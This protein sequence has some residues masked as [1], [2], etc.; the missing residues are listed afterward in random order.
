MPASQIASQLGLERDQVILGATEL[1]RLAAASTAQ[2]DRPLVIAVDGSYPNDRSS[3]Y[4]GIELL[5][6]LRLKHK[7]TA[8]ILLV[9]FQ[10][11]EDILAKHPEHLIM[12]APGNRYERLPLAPE[13]IEGLKQLLTKAGELSSN[14]LAGKYK[15]YLASAFDVGRF[16]HSIANIYALK[17]LWELPALLTAGATVVG[18]PDELTKVLD[19]SLDMHIALTLHDADVERVPILLLERAQVLKDELLEALN[20][21]QDRMY[22]L[23]MERRLMA[24]DR[25]QLLEEVQEYDLDHQL[26]QQIVRA[27]ASIKQE[28]ERIISSILAE[29]DVLD[30][31]VAATDN[32]EAQIAEARDKLNQAA[33]TLEQ[34]G[35]H[36]KLSAIGDLRVVHV[37]DQ[38]SLGWSALFQRMVYGAE[39]QDD[40][41]YTAVNLATLAV[42]GQVRLEWTD[43]MFGLIRAAI[44]HT[45]PH[46]L[47]LDLRL[48]PAFDDRQGGVTARM[49]GAEILSRIRAEYR[50][51]PVIVTTASNKTWGYQE[52]MALGADGYWVKEGV[53]GIA[54]LDSL[55][56]GYLHLYRQLQA[57]TTRKYD[58]LKQV[59][60]LL[61]TLSI[62]TDQA[63][64]E[65]GVWLNGAD[66]MGDRTSVVTTL[67]R[68]ID[69]MRAYLQR[70]VLGRAATC[71]AARHDALAGIAIT[72]GVIFEHVAMPGMSSEDRYKRMNQALR[73]RVGRDTFRD[74][75]QARQY[76][77]HAERQ[78]DLSERV[79]FTQ[80]QDLVTFL[81]TEPT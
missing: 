16:R 7:Y 40:R 14:D 1:P 32:V 19:R 52:M 12:L 54:T 58:L 68:L 66:R 61:R 8:P 41:R 62:S 55:L 80:V 81:R 47:L 51:L 64:W 10:P 78:E 3:R 2:Q 23:G 35:V 44:D 60:D 28:E 65:R 33:R 29:E 27:V 56:D 76:A 21:T 73:E 13:Q 15:P 9:G 43:T 20:T 25:W 72:A 53:D 69:Q 71:D 57:T 39:I 70:F 77:A 17:T 37:D 48:A 79:T 38:A 67:I 59:S 74:L 18:Y 34:K 75:T 50:T 36:A 26:R 5:M 11:A 31:Q 45:D 24:F 4:P 46:C 22:D 42:D 63:W 6:W 30:R 49:T